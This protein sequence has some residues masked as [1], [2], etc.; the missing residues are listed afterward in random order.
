[1]ACT[2]PHTGTH[3]RTHSNNGIP[4]P[5]LQTLDKHT[6]LATA[7]LQQIKARGLDSWHSG[8]EDVLAGRADLG[9]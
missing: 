3:D 8:G 2:H 1:M 7:L 5:P 9:G 4:R 6:N